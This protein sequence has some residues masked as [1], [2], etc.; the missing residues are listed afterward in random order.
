[1]QNYG[2]SPS[3]LALGINTMALADLAVDAVALLSCGKFPYWQRRNTPTQRR[4]TV[5]KLSL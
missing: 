1:M 2:P 3:A 4:G 5:I